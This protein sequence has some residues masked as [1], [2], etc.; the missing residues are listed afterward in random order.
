MVTALALALAAPLSAAAAGFT[1]QSL[2]VPVGVEG[3]RVRSSMLLRFEFERY[4]VPFDTFAS[5][6]RDRFESTLRDFVL[7][8]RA[9]DSAKVL[10]LRPGDKPE[11]ASQV[12]AIY[13]QAF[14]GQQNFKVVG[15][16]RVGDDQLFVCE[17]PEPDGPVLF[18]F[19]V[20]SIEQ[21][22]AR[23]EIDYSGRSLETLIIDAL[24]QEARSPREYAS[25]A[26]QTGYRYSL[27]LSTSGRPGAQPVML[28][29]NGVPL[30][31]KLF[32]PEAA[33]AAGTADAASA[34]D[35]Y[36]AAYQALKDGDFERFSDSYTDKSRDKLR[37]WFQ[38]KTA[39]ELKPFLAS[40]TMPRRLHF[41]LD[42]G[43]VALLF[44]TTGAEQRLRY[45]YLMKSGS[46]FKLTNAYF[47]DYLDD[48]LGNSALFPTDL[49]SFRKSVLG[50]SGQQ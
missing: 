44:Y 32:S 22:P 48:V 9:G 15:R 1:T 39:D 20:V 13:Q 21:R 31:M 8:L 47:E 5:G 29:F 6:S 16:A 7:A 41:Y 43:P 18:G 30:D 45:E 46:S 2:P 12:V 38:K 40:A 50:A 28:Y 14:P 34:I 37:A 11:Q 4:G 42:A 35:A 24:Q 26:S 3:G 23:V 49:A 27:S 25:V 33:K 19:T 17:R 36:R 10:T